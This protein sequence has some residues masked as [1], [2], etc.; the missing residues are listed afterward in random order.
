MF[1]CRYTANADYNA[2]RTIAHRAMAAWNA[3]RSM[4]SIWRYGSEEQKQEWL[5]RLATGEAIGCFGLTEPDFGS[6]PSGM[7]TRCRPR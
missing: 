7:R 6:N 3:G 5:P 2:S 4:F 1:A